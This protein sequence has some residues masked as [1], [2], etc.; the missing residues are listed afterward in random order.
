MEVFVSFNCHKDLTEPPFRRRRIMDFATVDAV[1][2][3][4]I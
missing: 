1:S 2:T 4:G 3:N